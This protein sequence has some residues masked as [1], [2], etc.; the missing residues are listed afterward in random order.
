MLGEGAQ[1]LSQCLPGFQEAGAE[2]QAGLGDEGTKGQA[3]AR[4]LGGAGRS[5]EG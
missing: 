4:L 1:G 2:D 3:E 5:P